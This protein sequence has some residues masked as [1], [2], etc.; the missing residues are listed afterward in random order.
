MFRALPTAA[1]SALI[2]AAAP[3][4]AAT[5]SFPV[6]GFGRISSSTPFDVRV[7]TGEE[8]SVRA[9]GPQRAL[10]RLR[11]EVRGGELVIGM[12]RGNW[13]SWSF[14]R[15]ERA[16]IDVTVPALSAARLNGPGDLTVDRV[17]GRDFA[18]ALNGPGNLSLQQIEVGVLTLD[19][20]G[21]GDIVAIGRAGRARIS[22]SGPGDVDGGRLTSSDLIVNL[23]G[24]G[25]VTTNARRTA[26]VRL[27]GPGDVRIRGG[28]KCTIQKVG[29]GDV[30][31]G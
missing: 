15:G 12:E 17:A 27:V 16:V 23:I 7:H 18:G 26:N 24:P 11:V 29:P 1:L 25:N 3:G 31:C 28:A 8:P 2:L 14:G 6:P 13:R 20:N 5:R 30:T 9:S 19:L 22:A 10:D 21:P 4:Q